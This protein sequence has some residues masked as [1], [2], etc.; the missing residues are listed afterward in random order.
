MIFEIIFACV[1]SA[2]IF[3]E[4]IIYIAKHPHKR[5]LP[6]NI[7][8]IIMFF[9]GMII[10]CGCNYALVEKVRSG[11]LQDANLEWAGSNE[12]N[13][14]D[15]FFYVIIR[16]VMDV[17]TMFYGRDHSDVFYK[18]EIAKKPWAVLIFWLV[19]LIAFY[20]AATALIIRFGK[21]LLRWIRRHSGSID[22]IILIFGV[23]EAS[24]ALGRNLSE[25][26]HLMLV[27]IDGK[28][29]EDDGNLIRE[30]G[31]VAYS[32]KDALN[33][34]QKFLKR[35]R[36]TPGGIKVKLYALSS[37]H[38]R[39]VNYA[40]YLLNS[41]K[42]FNIKPEQSEL[43][44]LGI[45]EFRG[46]NFINSED[47]YGYGDVISFDELEISARV[48]INKYPVCNAIKFDENAKALEGVNAL[49]VG[50]GGIGHAV[51]RKIIANSQFYGSKFKAVIYDPNFNR[52]DGFFRSQYPNMFANYDIE[53]E[54]QDG[55]G[56]KFFEFLN[57]NAAKLNYIVICIKDR[58][59]A[60]DIALKMIDRFNALGFNNKSVYTCD[61][62]SIRKYSQN[63][64]ECETN[65]IYDSEL[66][67]S[68]ELDAYAKE[69]N[70]RYCS[71]TDQTV[72]QNW[73]KCDYYS[74]M[75][76]R[77]AIDYLMPLIKKLNLK[78]LSKKQR[79]NLAHSEHMRWC[80][81][82]YT[83]GFELMEREEFIKRV[84]DF[85]AGAKIKTSRDMETKK[86]ICLVDWD[87]LDNISRLEN[88]IMQSSN[89]DYKEFDRQN[90]DMILKIL[91]GKN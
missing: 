78:T 36:V 53:F 76:S 90:V 75:N 63:T 45:D 8:F 37:D 71:G 49:I 52:R 26:E 57:Q 32:D 58:D 9:G 50:F 39:N 56:L 62:K 46:M 5:T 70:N 66:I 13:C 81:F 41:L 6:L 28:F 47:V 27:Y 18:L 12:S 73:K 61:Y 77:A 2:I 21:D 80:A 68:G 54:P 83:F 16:S 74:R 87:E 64:Q 3:A 42:D 31:G 20:T 38:D 33:A 85:K 48:L 14:V 67:Y 11:A 88:S 15:R 51:L 72:E 84:K 43:V 24:L 65:Y 69:L 82:Q 10:Y 7:A 1:I 40:R 4:L 59:M 55:R 34:S 89:K 86:H 25:Q 19:H 35:V 22:K 30:L 29:N 91:G 60:R 23:N 44:L 17:G 79:E